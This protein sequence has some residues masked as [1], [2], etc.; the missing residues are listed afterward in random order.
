MLIEEGYTDAVLGDP[1]AP[2]QPAP[3]PA[4]TPAHTLNLNHN[5]SI[6]ACFV[7]SDPPTHKRGV[8]EVRATPRTTSPATPETFRVCVDCLA[9]F[10][11]TLRSMGYTDIHVT[12]PE[13]PILT[14]WRG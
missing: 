10:G 4:P 14:A 13:Y 8:L 7:D 5:P 6:P 12:A 2:V 11:D 3:Q 1:N 9:D